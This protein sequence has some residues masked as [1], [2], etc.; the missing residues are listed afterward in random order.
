MAGTA[1]LI[2]RADRI[3][4]LGPVVLITLLSDYVYQHSIYFQYN[5]GIIAILFYL[6]LLNLRDLSDRWRQYLVIC[7][8][9]ASILSYAALC[10]PYLSVTDAYE[11]NAEAIE[12]YNE[13][14]E[15]VDR[16]RSVAA[17]TFFVPHLYDCKELYEVKSDSDAEQILLMTDGEEGQRYYATFLQRGYTVAWEEEGV[18]A[19][20]I[21]AGE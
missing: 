20:L 8:A 17:T 18:A 4:L 21:K 1:L 2:K 10:S 5:F 9:V 19:L 11:S 7:M 6:A 3:I 16:D 13:A 14:V 12:I 15:Q